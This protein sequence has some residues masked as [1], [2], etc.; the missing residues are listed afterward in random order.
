VEGL[1]LF[2]NNQVDRGLDLIKSVRLDFADTYLA[3]DATYNLGVCYVRL[4]LWDHAINQ[5]QQLSRQATDKLKMQKAKVL[6]GHCYLE[7]GQGDSARLVFNQY[8]KDYPAD[9]Y[10]YFIRTQ[11]GDSW[12]LEKQYLQAQGAYLAASQGTTDRQQKIHMFVQAG[13]MGCSANT[14]DYSRFWHQAVE[15][16]GGEHTGEGELAYLKLG[17]Y[18]FQQRNYAKA[19]YYYQ[20]LGQFYGQSPSLAWANYQTGNIYK[21]GRLYAKALAQYGEVEKKFPDS[22]WAQQASWKKQDTIWEENYQE[23][24]R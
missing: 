16:D 1:R 10:Q 22:F 3:D 2:L 9:R 24:L 23:V 11:I 12:K 19:L 13:L 21:A 4:K 5:F 15:L 8:L 6:L 18:Y 20:A 17:D 7:R 14:T